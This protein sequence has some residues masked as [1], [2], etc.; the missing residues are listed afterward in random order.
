MLSSLKTG[1]SMTS[2]ISQAR[3]VSNENFLA[4]SDNG[5]VMLYKLNKEPENMYESIM[6]KLEH[7]SIVTCL[8]T[9]FNSDIAL[10]GSED[11]KIKMWDLK[12]ELSIKTFKGN[13][14]RAVPVI[15]LQFLNKFFQKYQA[16]ESTVFSLSLNPKCAQTFLSCSDDNRA[17]IW[18]TRK[19]TPAFRIP[20]KFKG[21]PSACDWSSFDSN[22]IAIGSE[23]GQV[24]VFDVRYLE[25]TQ[26]FAMAKTNERL[27]RKV[28]FNPR[29]SSIATGSEDCHTQVYKLNHDS[30]S[31]GTNLEKM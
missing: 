16:H 15:I 29:N 26:T 7:D 23:N 30:A 25:A 21:H 17:L 11:C 20:H 8:A 9:N 5:E 27:I 22:L 4:A 24:G 18:D 2:G 13:F 12:D 14:S 3:W 28:E 1:K 31:N 6:L 10:S 19:E